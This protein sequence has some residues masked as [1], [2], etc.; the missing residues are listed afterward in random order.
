MYEPEMDSKTQQIKNIYKSFN[1]KTG[2]WSI[3]IVLIIILITLRFFSTH[4]S[5]HNNTSSSPSVVVALVQKSNIPVYLSALGTVIP[6][7][8]VTVK[9]QI[10]GRLIKVLFN[11]GQ[12]VKTGDLL[13]EIDP[14]PYEAQLLQYQGQ[15]ERDQALLANAKIDLERY[16]KLWAEDSVAKQ[17]LDTQSSLVKQYDGLV[18]IDQGQI[19]AVNVNLGYTRITSP[20]DGRVGLRLVD[21]GN[22]VQTTDTT[23]IAVINML[24]PITVVFT[25][26]EDSVPEVMQQTNAGKS[27]TVE[28]Y[29]R[30]QNKL[31]ATGTLM[32]VDNQIDP[33][34][35]TVKLKAQFNNDNNRLFPNQFVNVRLLIKT[36]QNATT[37]PTS[38]IQYGIPKTFVYLLKNNSTV[39]VQQVLVG[40]SEGNISTINLGVFPGQFVVVEGADK[41][42]DGMKVTVS[43]AIEP[44]KENSIGHKKP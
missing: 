17:V 37:I 32:T 38:A 11:E 14:S 23:G 22:F 25:L 1:R 29:D 7:Y 39:N 21:P 19:N 31:L 24:N 43:N 20:I 27:L 34:T 26:P 4:S 42:S 36:L 5:N 8:T 28:A 44:V 6:T 33:T 16:N 2:F 10:N 12:M 3:L 40:V 30:S 13:A 41:L 35:G 18:K 9:T 15:L